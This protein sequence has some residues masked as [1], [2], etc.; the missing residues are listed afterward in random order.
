MLWQ[1]FVGTI[2]S[3]Y[4]DMASNVLLHVMVGVNGCIND[5]L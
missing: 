1:Y 5:C 2:N 4:R 3:T